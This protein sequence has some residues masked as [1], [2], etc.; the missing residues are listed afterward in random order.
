MSAEPPKEGLP[1]KAPPKPAAK[2]PAKTAAK[3][4]EAGPAKEPAPPVL[5]AEPKIPPK[6]SLVAERL[7]ASSP[8]RDD[9]TKA[10]TM[11][12]DPR[13]GLGFVDIPSNRQKAFSDLGKDVL[14]HIFMDCDKIS[15]KDKP[16]RRVLFITDQTVFLCEDSGGVARCFQVSQIEKI[17]TAPDAS[18]YLGVKVPSEYDMILRFDKPEQR[19]DVI[20]VL[21]AV[22]LRMAGKELLEESKAV[23]VSDFKMSKPAKFAVTIIPQRTKAHLRKAMEN[24]EK[25]EYE[26]L[27]MVELVQGELENEHKQQVSAVQKEVDNVLGKLD[28]MNRKMKETQDAFSKQSIELEKYRKRVQEI[29]GQFGPNGE[30]PPNKDD[31]LRE[32]QRMIDTLNQQLQNEQQQRLRLQQLQQ[33]GNFAEVDPAN[34]PPEVPPGAAPPQGG[35]GNIVQLLQDQLAA[36]TRE[37]HELDMRQRE[38]V[39]LQDDLRRGDAGSVPRSLRRDR[40]AGEGSPVPGPGVMTPQGGLQGAHQPPPMGG[41]L[42]FGM[43]SN[44]LFDEYEKQMGIIPMNESEMKVDPFNRLYLSDVPPQMTAQF[45]ELNG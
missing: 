33:L 4:P 20:N 37:L 41:G 18:N 7:Q 14:L 24:M 42:P 43:G 44:Q 22:Y 30:A 36:R 32:M 39:S 11:A 9:P 12:T 21:K 10:F 45:S 40:P 26:K 15:S 1:P 16:L 19:Q 6:K 17:V 34:R 2:A 3:A 8:I 35:T 5:P 38:I 31:K 23:K 29:D 27:K 25:G 13:T 28:E